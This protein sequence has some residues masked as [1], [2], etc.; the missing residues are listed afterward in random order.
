VNAPPLEGIRVLDL[1]SVVVGPLATQVLGDPRLLDPDARPLPTKDGYVCLSANTDPQAFAFF[2]AIGRPE[3]KDDPHL[4]DTGFF[5]AVNHPT[6][7]RIWNMKVANKLSGGA[8]A[9]W[10]PAPRL[11]Q[12][13]REVLREAGY[14]DQDV[15]S[16]I[17]SGVA[18]AWD[19]REDRP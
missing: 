11:G 10:R 16:L 7:G 9:A 18:C 13:T 3:L 5:E 19:A 2:D 17:A 4:K 8:P 12:H 14:S 1:T 15:E 6:E